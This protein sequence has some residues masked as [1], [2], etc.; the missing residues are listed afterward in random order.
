M[1]NEPQKDDN[2]KQT[3]PKPVHPN[4]PR[5]VLTLY[6][7]YFF[8]PF[9]LY[10]LQITIEPSVKQ[11]PKMRRLAGGH[12]RENIHGGSFLRR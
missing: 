9:D 1:S 5:P 2:F 6:V 4:R 12:L 8:S 10:I 3:E 11:P 7:L